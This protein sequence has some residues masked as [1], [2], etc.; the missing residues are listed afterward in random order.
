MGLENLTKVLATGLITITTLFNANAA[1]H[2]NDTT[3]TTY[4]D[5]NS[6]QIKDDVNWKKTYP[7][8]STHYWDL[9]DSLK[10]SFW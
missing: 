8:T 4:E 1:V 2:N 10:K 3:K 5:K 6:G 9:R 7:N